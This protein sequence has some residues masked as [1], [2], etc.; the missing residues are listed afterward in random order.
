MLCVCG[1]CSHDLCTDNQELKRV[2]GGGKSLCLM[3]WKLYIDWQINF[4]HF[5]TVAVVQKFSGSV[6][7]LQQ[8]RPL[9]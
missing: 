8:M 6:S 3:G 4:N 5:D 2:G 7:C 9:I 1:S